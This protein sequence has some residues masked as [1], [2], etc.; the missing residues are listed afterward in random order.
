[1]GL[2]TLED[3]NLKWWSEIKTLL[4]WTEDYRKVQAALKAKQQGE[5]ESFLVSA[6]VVVLA[7]VV[8]VVVVVP[9][10]SPI[11]LPQAI[12]RELQKCR[13]IEALM[14][15]GKYKKAL[16]RLRNDLGF[17]D[18]DDFQTVRAP[19]EAA[20]EWVYVK[21]SERKRKMTRWEKLLEAAKE[22]EEED[23]RGEQERRASASSCGVMTDVV[24]EDDFLVDPAEVNMVCTWR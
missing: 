17:T 18:Y 7:V 8:V 13:K 15:A 14:E 23:K 2:E 20:G 6:L 1:M 24:T 3:K 5:E 19:L 9:S 22:E 10:I 21:R 4:P 12:E 11:V 16:K